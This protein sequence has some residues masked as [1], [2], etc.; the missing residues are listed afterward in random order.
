MTRTEM[1]KF[2]HECRSHA[3]K[4]HR[5]SPNAETWEDGRRIERLAD[6][7]LELLVELKYPATDA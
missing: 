1:R 7:V 4:W 5:D 2:A 3:K 6:I